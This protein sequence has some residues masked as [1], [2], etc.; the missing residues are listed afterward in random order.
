MTLEVEHADLK[1]KLD[2]AERRLNAIGD[3]ASA[4]V[5][6]GATAEEKLA[7][8]ELRLNHI[9]DLVTSHNA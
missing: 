2:D 1:V 3:V 6:G 4:E 9:A 5:A 8:A 7:D